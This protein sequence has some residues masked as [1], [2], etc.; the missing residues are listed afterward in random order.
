MVFAQFPAS[1]HQCPEQLLLRSDARVSLTN[2]GVLV[3]IRTTIEIRIHCQTGM[4]NQANAL[5]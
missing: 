2:R 4:P 3:I 1:H 5:E